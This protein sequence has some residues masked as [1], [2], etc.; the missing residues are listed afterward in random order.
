MKMLP[1]VA[2]Y[3]ASVKEFGDE[4]NLGLN[5]RL[6]DSLTFEYYGDFTANGDEKALVRI[7]AND[8]AGTAGVNSNNQEHCS[9]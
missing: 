8:G 5:N 4:V 2:S 3:Y 7:Y 1:P 9:M 6:L